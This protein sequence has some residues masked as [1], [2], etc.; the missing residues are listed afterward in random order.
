MKRFLLF[1]LIFLLLVF[2][3]GFSSLHAQTFQR[4]ERLLS[5]DSLDAF[6]TY[7][8]R[9]FFLATIYRTNLLAGVVVVDSE[10][11]PDSKD[12]PDEESGDVSPPPPSPST[13]SPSSSGSSISSGSGGGGSSSFSPLSTPTSPSVPVPEILALQSERSG[14]SEALVVIIARDPAILSVVCDF[15]NSSAQEEVV[16]VITP[17]LTHIERFNTQG[18]SRAFGCT[19]RITVGG[20]TDQEVFTVP[21][22]STAPVSLSPT[23]SLSSGSSVSVPSLTPP[24]PTPIVSPSPPILPTPT[25]TLFPSSFSE[26]PLF[27]SGTQLRFGMNTSLVFQMQ[28]MFEELG[29]LPLDTATGY[30]GQLTRRAVKDFVEERLGVV[31]TGNIAGSLTL[32]ELNRL[33]ELANVE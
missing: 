18:N 33:I 10:D 6:L 8:V 15:G 12:I 32:G 3:C 11:T 28:R 31:A 23:P 30:Y 16:S 4:E 5:I 2:G 13:P 9:N 19:A 26:F 17:K 29:Y 14:D 21:A 1:I 22:L 27:P 24:S 20:G 7:V 25:P